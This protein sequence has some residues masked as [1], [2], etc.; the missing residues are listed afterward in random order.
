MSAVG[1][2]SAKLPVSRSA[3]A[4]AMTMKRLLRNF[5]FTAG[6]LL[7]V[8]LVLVAIAAPL[9]APFDPNAQDTVAAARGAVARA[10]SSASTTSGA[11]FSRASSGARA[12]R[13]ASASASSSSRR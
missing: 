13:C 4:T 7:T 6:L 11:T 8:A 3:T 2:R 12:S 10:I 9:L 5:A 1:R